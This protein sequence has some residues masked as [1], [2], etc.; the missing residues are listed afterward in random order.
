MKSAF[1]TDVSPIIR[2]APLRNGG[3]LEPLALFRES[4]YR[5]ALAA[6]RTSAGEYVPPQNL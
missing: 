1:E 4:G 2:E 3:A 6:K 5:A